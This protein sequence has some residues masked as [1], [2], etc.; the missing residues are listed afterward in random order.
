MKTRGKLTGIQVP[1]RSQKPVISFEVSA[2]PADVE[3]FYNM[4]LD[5]SFAKHRESRSKDANACLWACLGEIAAALSADSWMVY[6][7]MLER[8]GKFTY[9]LVRPEAVEAVS[10]MWRE[11]KV[12][13][14]RDGMVQMLC[15][16]G[17]ST[18]DSKEFSRLLDGVISEM[19]EMGLPTPPS[20]EMRACIAELERKERDKARRQEKARES[21]TE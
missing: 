15:F 1:F 3:Q 17:S 5:I 21:C 10:K 2:D 8:Y 12:V 6:L 7:Y 14:E 19:K 16:F 11:T 9:I 13:G 18:Y 20:E 4:D